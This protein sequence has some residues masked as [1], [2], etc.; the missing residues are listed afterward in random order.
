MVTCRVAGVTKAVGYLQLS[1][2]AV[3]PPMLSLVSTSI[4][5][6][7]VD[8]HWG[9]AMKED[10]EALLSPPGSWLDSTRVLRPGA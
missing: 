10:Y 6:T 5:S 2:G 1:V 4:H 3:A 7:L 8:S 9:R